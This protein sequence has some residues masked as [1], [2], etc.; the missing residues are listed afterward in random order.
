MS[1]TICRPQ[2]VALTHNMSPIPVSDSDSDNDS[3][4]QLVSDGCDALSPR[5]VLTC[6]MKSTSP[7]MERLLR[8]RRG[9][10]RVDE[11]IHHDVWDGVLAEGC[12]ISLREI[13]SLAG[14]HLGLEDNNLTHKKLLL[15]SWTLGFHVYA[16]DSSGGKT[17]FWGGGM[18]SKTT[19]SLKRGD[20]VEIEGSEL[21]RGVQTSRL[22]RMYCG[23]RIKNIK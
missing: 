10:H 16:V 20:W 9:M 17:H 13:V 3:T 11:H 21:C 14:N 8:G 7:A 18:T 12:P 6:S 19:S 22:G 15:C 5:V 1:P 4:L 23:V 2:Y